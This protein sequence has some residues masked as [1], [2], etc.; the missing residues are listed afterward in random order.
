MLQML[1]Q[2]EFGLGKPVH[3][4]T[5]KCGHQDQSGAKVVGHLCHAPGGTWRF[6]GNLNMFGFIPGKGHKAAVCF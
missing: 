6:V 3:I 4:H 2:I 5:W 1:S